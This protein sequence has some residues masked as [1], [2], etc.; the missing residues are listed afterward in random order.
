MDAQQQLVLEVAAGLLAQQ[1]AVV[2]QQYHEHVLQL[3]DLFHDAFVAR[4]NEFELACT[5]VAPT[6]P[7]GTTAGLDM[8]QKLDQ[9]IDHY[10]SVSEQEVRHFHDEC[11]EIQQLM[12]EGAFKS[13][14]E[15]RA[16]DRRREDELSA[17]Q[18]LARREVAA[19]LALMKT[20]QAQST[21]EITAMKSL[22][23]ALDATSAELTR[24]RSEIETVRS[25][26]DL[27]MSRLR[28]NY[29]AERAHARESLR[30]ERDE[31]T[32]QIRKILD[33]AD[34]ARKQHLQE[35]AQ[36]N[37]DA[38]CAIHM[39]RTDLQSVRAQMEL[40]LRAAD[41]SSRQKADA[42]RTQAQERLELTK[43]ITTLEFENERLKAAIETERSQSVAA[44]TDL[45]RALEIRKNVEV[46]DFKR[47]LIG[48]LSPH[49]AGSNGSPKHGTATNAA[50]RSPTVSSYNAR[51]ASGLG[52]GASPR[53]PSEASLHSPYPSQRGGGGMS[54]SDHQFQQQHQQ[55]GASPR[56]PSALDSTSAGLRSPSDTFVRLQHLSTQWKD[57]M[58]SM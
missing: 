7:I 54:A 56:G 33:D 17:A 43:T 25:T 46:E 19:T 53:Q 5:M 28:E 34:N 44:G 26:A 11:F 6:I 13:T 57:R 12:R 16:M 55:R 36:S 3:I 23:D 39:L 49:A 52:F 58:S 2:L 30:L 22:R 42:L 20:E 21:T 35:L 10:R 14:A 38:N 31:T 27:E 32:R 47:R 41:E 24:L 40:A 4:R 45:R 1:H 29:D 37:A 51:A 9:V 48:S 18:E 8:A 15:S 50:G